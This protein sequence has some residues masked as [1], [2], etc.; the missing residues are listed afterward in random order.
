M[1]LNRTRDQNPALIQTAAAL[2]QEGA[3]PPNTYLFDADAFEANGRAIREAADREGLGLYFK[4]K[5]HGRNPELFR[6]IVA[7]GAR[8]T[9]S[10]A[11]E[12]ARILHRHGIGLG[13]IG[14]LVQTPLHELPKV[15]GTYRPEVMSVFTVAK[16]EQIGAA[17]RTAGRVQPVLMRVHSRDDVL[18]PGMEGGFYLDELEAAAAQVAA[19]DGV[20]LVGVTSFPVLRYDSNG[21]RPR[22]TPNLESQGAARE[23]LERM[24]I[25]VRQV[26]AAGN[27]AAITMQTLRSYGATHVEPGSALTG[28]GTFHLYDH[29]LVE[30]PALVYVTEVAHVWDGLVYVYGG[31]FFVDDPPVPLREG[32]RRKALVGR[33]PDDILEREL[34]WRGIGARGGGSFAAIDYHGILEQD[35]PVE[36]GD[37]VIF[38]FRPQMFMTRA[39]QGV[40]EGISQ[41]SP[42]LVGVWDWATHRVGGGVE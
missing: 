2:H 41:G 9:V 35:V 23:V 36:V 18:F 6:R 14:N 26:N 13:H 42:R 33:G 31:G 17:A 16:A 10:V 11:M 25:E 30:R 24:G 27:T 22:A 37:T 40:V 39:Y 32:F 38:A 4:T 8:E 29:G 12:D 7:P 15:V 28:M 19:V 5:Q 1:F 3:I 20:E 34:T 21:A